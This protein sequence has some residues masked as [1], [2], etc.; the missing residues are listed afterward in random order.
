MAFDITVKH[1]LYTDFKLTWELMRDCFDGEDAV[2]ARG[3]RYLPMKSATAA[4][5]NPSLREKSYQAYK[6]R[7]EFPELVSP[8]VRGSTGIILDKSA[9]IELPSAMEYLREAATRDGMTLDHLHRAVVS[10]VLQ[11]GRFGLLPSV[12][13]DG[14]FYLAGY[15]A[16]AIINWDAKDEIPNYVVLDESA[17][18]R[19]PITNAWDL[20]E[21]FLELSVVNGQYIAS[22]HV[23]GA[24]GFTKMDLPFAQK[25]PRQGVSE[26]LGFLPFVF[27]NTNS[28]GHNP[29]D[30]PLFGLAKVSIRIYRMDAD[31]TYAL[32]M[33]SEPTPWVNGFDNPVEA[34]KSGAIPQTIGG[35][36]L[37]VLPTNSNA[38]YLEFSGPGLAAQ[39]S[40]I[41]D[42]LDR[43]TALGAQILVDRSKS[44]ESGEALSM[45]LGNQASTLK[46]IAQTTAAGLERALRNIALW[47]NLDPK[48]V[49]VTPNLDFFDQ[50]L[51][52]SEISA[53]VS[54]WT[55]GAY[56]WKTAFDRLKKG[57]I[58]PED[59]TPEDEEGFIAEDD[60]KR[61]AALEQQQ[62]I[63]ASMGDPRTGKP[64]ALPKKRLVMED[65]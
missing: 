23:K 16:E 58:I 14:Q 45:R 18:E 29:D 63:I 55:N 64:L 36:V 49:V 27:I 52:A 59:R 35:S 19:N 34:K 11:T 26:P 60:A 6:H 43:A 5:D 56:S 30:V 1:P 44:A 65:E 13:G 12:A 47:M 62:S 41:N 22:E 51:S 9:K 53:I 37:W 39:R 20:V 54:G 40:A 48:S 17:K 21:R 7:A 33:T 24:N 2:K 28:L 38:G 4:I 46:L 57:G 25:P 31:Y 8:T 61:G 50:P 10:E 32:H 42:A 15:K 3:E